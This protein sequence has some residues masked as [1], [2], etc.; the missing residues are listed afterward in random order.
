MSVFMLSCHYE[1]INI[2]LLAVFTFCRS[3][4]TIVCQ[5]A[6]PGALLSS[7][8]NFEISLIYSI[9]LIFNMKF[10]TTTIVASALLLQDAAGHGMYQ[11]VYIKIYNCLPSS[12]HQACHSCQEHRQARSLLQ[13]CR[14]HFALLFVRPELSSVLGIQLGSIGN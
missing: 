12:S 13:Q 10:T 4:L 14:I 6:S 9:D 1:Y 11:L 8:L 7:V 5:R 2:P 3:S